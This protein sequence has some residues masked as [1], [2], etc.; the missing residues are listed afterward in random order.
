VLKVDEDAQLGIA[1]VRFQT[2]M[3]EKQSDEAEASS[4][5][6]TE[7]V[8]QFVRSRVGV[9]SWLYVDG[10]ISEPSDEEFD[11]LVSF[12]GLT[13]DEYGD[14][15]VGAVAGETPRDSED[16]GRISATLTPAA[17]AAWKAMKESEKPI[18]R[19]K[20]GQRRKSSGRGS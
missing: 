4:L 9:G 1:E 10:E 18:V 15:N 11:A 14:Q 2:L 13:P 7:E 17:L 8:S 6:A 20:R 5:I 16:D 19:D 12:C 3:R